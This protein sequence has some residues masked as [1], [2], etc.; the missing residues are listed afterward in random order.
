EPAWDRR[1]LGVTRLIFVEIDLEGIGAAACLKGEGHHGNLLGAV[2]V[3]VPRGDCQHPGIARATRLS[4]DVTPLPQSATI[5]RV[6]Q[7]NKS[8]PE[9]PGTEDNAGILLHLSNGARPGDGRQSRR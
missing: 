8:L 4:G 9:C 7:S 6:G 1:M 3:E 2:A 5:Q